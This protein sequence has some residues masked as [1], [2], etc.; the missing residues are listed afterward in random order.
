M[1]TP[2]QCRPPK[3]DQSGVTGACER[4]IKKGLK[5]DC[6]Y[7]PVEQG[8]ASNNY[9]PQGQIQDDSALLYPAHH[10]PVAN[11]LQYPPPNLLPSSSSGAPSPANPP[12]YQQSYTPNQAYYTQA[13]SPTNP[14]VSYQYQ[15]PYTPNRAYYTQTAL[16]T[17]PS[18]LYAGAFASKPATQLP[19]D[20][21]IANGKRQWRGKYYGLLCERAEYTHRWRHVWKSFA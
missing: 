16:Y 5:D 10:D 19:I 6:K 4:C 12:Q 17:Q 20:G 7:F 3:P 11:R 2:C 14:P 9:V 18:I 1:L 21:K 15:Q 8:E 13:P